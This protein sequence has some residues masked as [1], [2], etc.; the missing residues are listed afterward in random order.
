[1]NGS[2]LS[3]VSHKKDLGIANSNNLKP[4]KHC[5]DVV[6]TANKLVVY[7]GRTFEN[8]KLSQP[9]RKLSTTKFLGGIRNVH[10]INSQKI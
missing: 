9:E 4:S 2:D 6:K 7:N 5:L 8:S 10:F 1:M 3:K